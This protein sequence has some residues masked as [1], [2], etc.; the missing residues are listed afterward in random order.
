MER[1]S[2]RFCL[3][4]LGMALLLAGCRPAY[5]I[6]KFNR[7]GQMVASFDIVTT[8]DEYPRG[9]LLYRGVVYALVFSLRTADLYRVFRWERE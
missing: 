4:L 9:V 2:G 8:Q 3:V 6:H 1:R 5:T 7:R